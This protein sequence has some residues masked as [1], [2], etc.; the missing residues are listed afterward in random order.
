M[1]NVV[2]VLFIVV[3]AAVA[4]AVLGIPARA[5][6]L[7][8]QYRHPDPT[9]KWLI[10]YEA[11]EV[12]DGDK[13]HGIHQLLIEG[14]VMAKIEYENRL[15]VEVSRRTLKRLGFAVRVDPRDEQKALQIMRDHDVKP[16]F[17]VHGS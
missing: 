10:I 12:P 5:R 15:S 1:E 2:S 16:R 14:G 11:M 17:L 3:I 8:A 13:A 6:S 7:I 4:L 9:R